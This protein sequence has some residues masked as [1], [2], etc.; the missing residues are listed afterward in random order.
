MQDKKERNE[1]GIKELEKERREKERYKKG[2]Q[3]FKELCER[4]KKENLK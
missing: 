2:T 1:K 4:K 3:E